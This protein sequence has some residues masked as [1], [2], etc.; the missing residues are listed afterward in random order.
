LSEPW[1]G[2]EGFAGAGGYSPPWLGLEGLAGYVGTLG[3]LVGGEAGLV[4]V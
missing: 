2:V 1:L 3:T 4:M